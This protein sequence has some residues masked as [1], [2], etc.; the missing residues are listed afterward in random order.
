MGT[1]TSNYWQNLSNLPDFKA[2]F[3]KW[4]KRALS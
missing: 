4:K 1:P 2:T 3:P